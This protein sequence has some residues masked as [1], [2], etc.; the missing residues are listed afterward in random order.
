MQLPPGYPDLPP[1]GPMD[2]AFTL[3]C[4]LALCFGL[5]LLVLPTRWVRA[6]LHDVW[7]FSRRSTRG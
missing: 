2:K 5:A 3:L 1:T 7:P 4:L 6:L